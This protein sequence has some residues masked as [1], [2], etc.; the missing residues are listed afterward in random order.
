MAEAQVQPQEKRRLWSARR[1]DL[2][3]FLCLLLLFLVLVVV[4]WGV[5]GRNLGELGSQVWGKYS[6][7]REDLVPL[8]GLAAGVVAACVALGQL[9]TAMRQASIAADRHQKQTEADLQRRITES[10]TKAV[11]QLGSDKLVARLGGIYALERISRESDGD[12]WTVM[13]TLTAFVRERARWKKV[14]AAVGKRSNRARLARKTAARL[15]QRGTQQNANR[16]PPTDVAAVLTV[17]LRRYERNREREKREGWRMDLRST[18]L[19]G[20]NLSEAHLEG[21]RLSGAHLEGAVLWGARLE[22]AH[23][24]GAVLWGGAPRTGPPR[25]GAPR[26]GRPPGSR[27]HYSSRA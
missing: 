7:N 9:A 21:A 4:G 3:L 15:K 17:I 16:E 13:E 2:L 8:V 18:D 20:A 25:G 14:G 24:E 10:F 23:L 1:V 26:R 11:E 22:R 27:G 5:Q 6:T 12:Y 19:R